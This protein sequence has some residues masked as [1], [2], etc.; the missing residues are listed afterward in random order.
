MSKGE[1]LEILSSYKWIKVK[2]PDFDGCDNT[3]E[4]FDMLD[5]HHIQETEFLINKCRELAAELLNEMQNKD[6]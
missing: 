4:E 5:K 2:Q 6:E 3:Q 1:L